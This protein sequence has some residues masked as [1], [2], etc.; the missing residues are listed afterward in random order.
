MNTVD[1]DED[2]EDEEGN[3]TVGE[4]ITKNI[5]KGLA[6]EYK[7][8]AMGRSGEENQRAES[9]KSVEKDMEVCCGTTNQDPRSR[10]DIAYEEK[11][12]NKVNSGQES[13]KIGDDH[14]KWEGGEI[15][16]ASEELS[17]Y[18][19]KNC[20]F[21]V[22]SDMSFSGDIESIDL[23]LRIFEKLNVH[24]QSRKLSIYFLPFL[25][26]FS[27]SKAHIHMISEENMMEEIEEQ[28]KRIQ[29]FCQIILSILRQE[30]SSDP[31]NQ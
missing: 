1:E 21:E 16:R 14:I 31:G 12:E 30:K 29:W 5:K 27:F 7:N 2:D 17:S 3:M 11:E 6:S 15:V 4:W 28:C 23:V 8:I 20:L 13:R 9:S 18:M 26:I 22:A 25:D 19:L 10:T 24:A